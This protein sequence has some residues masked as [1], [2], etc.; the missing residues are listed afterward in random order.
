ML[1][2]A[3]YEG[4]AVVLAFALSLLLH[5]LARIENRYLESC[6]QTQVPLVFDEQGIKTR[7]KIDDILKMIK[8][9]RGRLKKP[10]QKSDCPK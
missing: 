8:S 10:L 6:F 3:G 7:I 9:W 5:L 2:G 4:P 1:C